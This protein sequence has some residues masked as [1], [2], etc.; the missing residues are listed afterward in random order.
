[1][2]KINE[3]LERLFRK[4]EDFKIGDVVFKYV[5]P[6]TVE[7]IKMSRKWR[8]IDLDNIEEVLKLH[9]EQT[10]LYFKTYEIDGKTYPFTG[11][12]YDKL[13][14][15]VKSAFWTFISERRESFHE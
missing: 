6:N 11:E 4:K 15:T 2:D 12:L 9:K 5:E 14:T 7:S 1:M 13:S 10:L 3:K 8:G